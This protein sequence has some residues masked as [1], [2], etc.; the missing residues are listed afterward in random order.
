[1]DEKELLEEDSSVQ[2]IPARADSRDESA[3]QISVLVIE[4]DVA[5]FKIL[6]RHLDK[7]SGVSFRLER[8]SRLTEGL[9]RLAEGGIH[10][11]LLDLG[12]PD[13]S[14]LETFQRVR[15]HTPHVPIIVLT[16]LDDESVAIQAA[17]GGAQDYLVK[18]ELDCNLLMRSIRYSIARHRTQAKLRRAVQ[19]A[20]NSE[21][22][23]R[24]LITNSVDGIIVVDDQGCVQ[25]SNMAAQVLLGR[26]E[27]QLQGEAVGFL[28]AAGEAAEIEIPQDGGGTVQVEIRV[29][30]VEWQG[31]PACLA[32]LHDLMLRK[33]A[34]KEHALLAAIVDSTEDAVIAADLDGIVLTWNVG[35]EKLYGYSAD[36]VVGKHVLTLAAPDSRD[37]SI[38][39]LERV[40]RGEAVIQYETVAVR[41]D[42]RRIDVAL[43][44][45]PLK[46]ALGE[47]VR[48]AGVVR[49]ISARRQAE[50]ERIR[51]V[52]AEREIDIARQVQQK[53]FPS[54]PPSL[55]GFD[56]AGRV[57][58]ADQ[59]SGD[60]FDYIP[61]AEGAIGVVVA[62][63]SG[64]G[65]GP[66][67]L[68]AQ[69][70]AYLRAM[71]EVYDDPGQILTSTNQLL[72]RNPTD[73]H[74]T[75]FLARI[76]ARARSFV[77]SSAGHRGFLLNA[78][79]E[80]KSLDS[81]DIALGVLEE[82][83]FSCAPAITL[84]PGNLIL[85]PT[86]G[87]EEARSPESE[88]F[89]ARRTLDVLRANR[90]KPA[91][92][93]VHALYEAARDFTR[94]GAQHDDITAV[95]IKIER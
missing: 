59:T 54:F 44:V 82:H 29:V 27:S 62:D 95:V 21:A 42:G 46:N 58:P 22:S 26:G 64:H 36:E 16:G 66:A 17:M 5:D 86:D 77:Y 60:Y 51:R 20:K 41:K 91:S 38:E 31:K 10:V 43:T 39:I 23:L 78:L 8:A 7:A 88:L 4:D 81:T 76:D 14:G 57:D 9:E 1:M 92:E 11:V 50:E 40:K 80:V 61:I 33:E 89:G 53:L 35:A 30:G 12:L 3:E 85:L 28:L 49:D 67:L 71:A 93:I 24:N 32:L 68:M 65:L 25:F 15:N 79:G 74:V 48:S 18:G 75:L 13:S 72:N 70:Q 63:V 6:N 52:E 55:P 83:H 37:E 34:E 19:D 94:G 73:K 47:V 87:I 90:Q 56:I 69:I 2:L 84:E 45:C